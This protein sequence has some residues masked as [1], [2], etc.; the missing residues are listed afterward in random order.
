MTITT[1]R[2]IAAERT[3]AGITQTELADAMSYPRSFISYVES[4]Q[5]ITPTPEFAL[6]VEA[7]IEHLTA[8]RA[9]SDA[10]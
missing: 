8:E 2:D 6:R 4:S 9:K 7:T 5:D 3:R 10:A 1:G